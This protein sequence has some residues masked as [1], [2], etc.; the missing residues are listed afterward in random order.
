MTSAA[1]SG[2]RAYHADE[3]DVGTPQAAEQDAPDLRQ[4]LTCSIGAEMI[5]M[6]VEQLR[7]IIEFRGLTEIPM[8]PAF[9]RGVLNLRGS[10]V[11]VIDLAQRLDRAPTPVA[12]R[13][14]IV[15][16]ELETD[17]GSMAVGVLVAGVRGMAG[18]ALSPPVPL[19]P[20]PL[21]PG[22]MPIRA[23]FIEGMITVNACAMAALDL[24]RTLAPDDL[25]ALIGRAAGERARHA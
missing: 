11:P 25:A 12:R 14:C 16:A 23:D 4:F 20:V 1:D 6:P 24:Q 17:A 18:A 2:N 21:P 5:A 9:L 15:I 7:E 19:P 10:V 8:T 3:P 22:T 13:A